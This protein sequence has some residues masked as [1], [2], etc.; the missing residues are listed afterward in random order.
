MSAYRLYLLICGLGSFAAR[1]AFTLNLIYQASIGLS[2][3]QLVLVGTLMETVCFIAQVPTGVIADLR[4]RRLSVLLGY[5]LMGAGLLVW[6]LLPSFGAILLANVIWS[7]GAVCVDG[8]EEAW[9]ADEIE[10][11]LVT[12]AFLR[13]GQLGQAGSLLGIAAATGLALFGLAVPIVA[14]GVLTL[15]LGVLLVVFMKE[16]RWSPAET[17]GSWRSMGRQIADGVGAVRRSTLLA[18]IVAGTLFAGM[19]SEGFD[20]LSQ[21][22]LLPF[23]SFDET[24]VFGGL[25][26]AAALGSI[27]LTGLIGR[28]VDTTHPRRVGELMTV[29][30]VVT[31]AGMITFGLV[32]QW[33]AAFGLYLV[34]RLLR[35]TAAPIMTIWMV[36]ATSAESRATVFSIQAQADALGQVVGGPPAG[37]VGSR[38][39]IGAGISVAGIFLLPAAVLFSL[40]ARRSPLSA[41]RS[42]VSR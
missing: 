26:M 34:V 11:A 16:Q 13:G 9:A 3:L 31:A 25:A 39:S 40:A 7:I 8:A 17:R 22:L 36:S 42:S 2:P 27:A 18:G 4:S 35:D 14:G 41:E 21:P 30:Q 19:S 5:L 23:T 15:A 10:P 1:T 6:G 28:Y 38:V 12:K 29:L 20:R 32:G 33:W 24:L 37:V